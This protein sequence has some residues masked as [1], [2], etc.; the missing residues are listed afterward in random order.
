MAA[1]RPLLTKSQKV[2]IGNLMIRHSGFGPF[3]ADFE[4]S[5]SM[6]AMF[7]YVGR[8]IQAERRWHEARRLGLGLKRRIR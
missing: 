6:Q 4:K 2:R 3:P 7:R 8:L 5:P 1:P